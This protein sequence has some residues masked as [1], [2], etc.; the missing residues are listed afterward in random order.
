MPHWAPVKRAIRVISVGVK[1]I[2]IK[3]AVVKRGARIRPVGWPDHHCPVYI[4]VSVV[5]IYIVPVIVDVG[6]V[7][8]IAYPVS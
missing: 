1:A 7:S 8:R 5:N 2:V 3:S 4:D 6:I